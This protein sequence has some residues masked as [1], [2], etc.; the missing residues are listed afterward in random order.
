MPTASLIEAILFFRNEPLSIAELSR[1]CKVGEEEITQALNALSATLEG[2]GLRI[3]LNGN[4]VALAAAPEAAEIIAEIRK[5]ELSKDL[6]KAGAETL[7]IILYEGPIS[8]SE[9]DYIRGVNSSF[10]VRNL[11]IRGLVERSEEKGGRGVKYQA[12]SDLIAFMGIESR[13]KLPDFQKVREQI[14]AFKAGEK[15]ALESLE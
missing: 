11:L 13:E 2:R 1:I 5:E 3:I 9:I 14:A 10:I 6:G 12:T 15:P 4:E 8:R 7:A